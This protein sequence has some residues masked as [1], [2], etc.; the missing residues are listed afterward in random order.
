MVPFG[1]I[2]RILKIKHSLNQWSPQL[3]ALKNLMV[4]V[5]AFQ[6]TVPRFSSGVTGSE[7]V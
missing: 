1:L 3:Q 4:C 7:V 5:E 2:V 6:V